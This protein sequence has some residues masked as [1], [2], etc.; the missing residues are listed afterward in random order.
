MFGPWAPVT[1]EHLRRVCT[2]VR[3]KSLP[4]SSFVVNGAPMPS[5]FDL[6]SLVA[7]LHMTT[8]WSLLGKFDSEL[9]P[10]FQTYAGAGTLQVLSS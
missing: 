4:G 10:N 1:R 8:H 6:A 5:D 3:F 9:T 2:R 7:E